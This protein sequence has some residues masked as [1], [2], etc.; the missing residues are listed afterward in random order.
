LALVMLV[1]LLLLGLRPI[2]ERFMNAA[3]DKLGLKE[4]I[5][6]KGTSGPVVTKTQEIHDLSELPP[7][8]ASNPEVQRLLQSDAVKKLF[9]KTT[10][11]TLERPLVVLGSESAADEAGVSLPAETHSD[12]E[13]A[14]PEIRLFDSPAN[15]PPELANN[16]HIKS[17]L[18]RS[19]G[20]VVPRKK[21]APSVDILKWA[22]VV[23]IIL[24]LGFLTPFAYFHPPAR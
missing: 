2:F 15:L 22:F 9:E 1:A 24:V 3:F 13:S 23:L 17:L 7:E 4:T 20:S 18:A 14:G 5:D 16:P 21:S 12:S 19:K 10:M 8:L 6:F 11:V